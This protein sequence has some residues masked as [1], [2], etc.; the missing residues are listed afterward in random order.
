MMFTLIITLIALIEC[1]ILRRKLIFIRNNNV[2]SV[3]VLG[4]LLNLL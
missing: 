3:A 2:P 1:F 4:F